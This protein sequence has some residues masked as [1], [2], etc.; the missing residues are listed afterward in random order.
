MPTNPGH[1]PE[2]LYLRSGD[3]LYR[4]LAQRW[5]RVMVTLFAVGVITGTVL[6]FEMGLLWPNFMGP[7]GGCSDWGSRSRSRGRNGDGIAAPTRRS[8]PRLVSRKSRPD[9]VIADR[10]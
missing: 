4:T 10:A 3:G 1:A 7:F 6:S 8:L 9:H 5:S 2:W